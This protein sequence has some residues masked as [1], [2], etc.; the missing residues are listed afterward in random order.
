MNKNHELLCAHSALI[1]AAGVGVGGLLITGWFP[2]LQPWLSGDEVQA[3]FQED[4]S[5]IRLGVAILA[6]TSALWWTASAA[7]AMQ[8]RRME[9]ES[10]PYTYVQIG[11]ASGTA[12]LFLLAALLWFAAAFRPETGAA[13]LQIFNDLAWISFIGGY[14]PVFV[15]TLILG[16]ATLSNPTGADSYPRWYGYFCIW[17]AIL[18]LPGALIPFFQTGP[19]AWNGFLAFWVAAS[20]FFAWIV[21]TWWLT[22]Q[23]IKRQ[24][25]S[26]GM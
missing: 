6:F 15:Q 14:P 23:A 16:M 7:F 26:L 9:G 10:H 25:E 18:A 20:V 3:I 11:T 5:R 13:Q 12:M 2:P 8:V 17:A 1:L 19:F 24:A 4:R 22:V 21:I